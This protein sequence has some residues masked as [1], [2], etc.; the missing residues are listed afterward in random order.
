[1]DANYVDT[2]YVDTNELKDCLSE[3]F[4]PES[5][6]SFYDISKEEYEKTLNSEKNIKTLI[7][8]NSPAYEKEE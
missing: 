8:I 1:M 3:G 2:N 7:G 5:T 4:T 6:M